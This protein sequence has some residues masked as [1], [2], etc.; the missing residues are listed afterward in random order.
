MLS[1]DLVFIVYSTRLPIDTE[2]LVDSFLHGNR[3][4]DANSMSGNIP[5]DIGNLTNLVELSLSTNK[6]NGAIPSSIGY[7][8]KLEYLYHLT[9]L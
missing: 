2:H 3:R 9:F 6:F 4:L 8:E 7:L 1:F 5:A